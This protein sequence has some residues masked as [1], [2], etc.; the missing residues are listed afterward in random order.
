MPTYSQGKKVIW[1]NITIEGLRLIEYFPDEFIA[2]KN[3][4][5]MKIRLKNGSLFQVIGSDNIDSLMGTNP[6]IVVFSEYALQDPAAWDYIRPILRVNKGV[7]IFISTPRGRNHFYELCRT[8]QTTDGWFYERLSIDDTH[9]LTSNDI[10]QERKDGMSE[11]LIQ[12]EYYCSFDRGVEGSYYAQYI[13]NMREKERIGSYNYD[14]NKFVYTSWD[15][16]WE[17]ATAVIFFQFRGNDV[18]IIDAIEENHT[19]LLVFKDMLDKKSYRYGGHL[20]PHDVENID[21]LISGCTRKEYLEDLKIPVTT[22]PK[23]PVVEG[24]NAVNALFT[25]RLHINDKCL[26]LIKSLENYHRNWDDKKKIYQNRPFHDWSSHYADA[27]RYLA[28]GLHLIDATPAKSL[29]NEAKAL[30]SFW[31]NG[32]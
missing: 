20:F 25:G 4:Q 14:P 24:I 13:V 32:F 18:V 21:G 29:E 9:V 27:L 8:A 16:G 3:N 11:E 23:M 10:E 2:Q 31:G 12:Q 6:K 7:A 28:T 17:D 15:L 26:G 30:R 1:D 19:K 22:V 5:E